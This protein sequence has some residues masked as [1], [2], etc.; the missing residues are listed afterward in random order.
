MILAE[1][2][3]LTGAATFFI[4]GLITGIWKYAGIV[5]SQ[6]AEAPAYV[7]ILH[8]ACLLYSF[9]CLVLF[10]LAK[11]SAFS[12]CLNAWAVSV[13]IFF[14]IFANTTYLI[15]AILKDTDNQF[16]KPH[17]LG[18]FELS[19]ALFHFSMLALIA[20]EVG[21]TLVLTIGAFMKIWAI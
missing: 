3:A 17:R 21:G 12:D 8:R 13:V 2:I 14:F 6:K 15:H 1:K 16:K 7:S 18:K 9:A 10:H 5:K 19:P 11:F 4:F 20:G